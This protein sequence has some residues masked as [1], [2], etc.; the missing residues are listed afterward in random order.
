MNIGIVLFICFYLIALVCYFFS[1]TSKNTKKRAINKIILSLSF[2]IFSIV[3]YINNYLFVDNII[4]LIGAIGL[5]F[6]GDVLLLVSFKK[7]GASFFLS[8]LL[9]IAYES[10]LIYI[11]KISFS[12]LWHA[13]VLT[14]IIFVIFLIYS[15]KT[16]INYKDKKIAIYLYLIT[17]TLH[18]CLGMALALYFDNLYIYLLGIGLVLFM[19]S[20]YLLMIH[21]FKYQN[22]NLILII[23][24]ASYFIGLLMVVLS[25]T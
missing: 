11:N 1:E 20:D 22:N 18:A 2:F 16:N 21:K 4:W 13:L 5:A 8:N 25:L 23:H 19:I 7:G 17:V 15:N 9:F 6:L 12:K 24:S 14:I 3:M 10:S